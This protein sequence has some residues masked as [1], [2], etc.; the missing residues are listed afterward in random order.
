MALVVEN[1]QEAVRHA[2]AEATLRVLLAGMEWLPNQTGGLNRYYHDLV[3][4]LPEAGV[5][6]I[7]LVS[8]LRAGQTAPLELR[9]LTTRGTGLADVWRDSRR[10]V[11]R[12]L[13]EKIGLVNAH[14]A[15]YAW[16]WLRE[17][18]PSLPFVVHFHG[19][20]AD[21]IAMEAGKPL[22]GGRVLV[23]RWLERRVY[24]RADRVITLSQ[25]FA[26][27]AHRGYGVE[28]GKI[29]VV[30][31][32][33]DAAAFRSGPERREAR[34]RLGWPEEKRILLSVRRLTPRMGLEN[35]ITAFAA[36]QRAH[37]DALLFLAGKGPLAV[38]LQRQIEAAGLADRIRL[39]GFIPDS[40][41][42]LAYAAADITV[43]PTVALE[44]FGLVSLES[45]TAGTP[46]LGTPVGGTPEVL[47]DLDP[48]LL[49]D[50]ATP[51]ALTERLDA[52][53][54]GQFALPDRAA[55]R[56]YAA[57]FDWR[58]IAPRVRAVYDEARAIRGLG[59]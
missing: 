5:G 39:L 36:L 20:W 18:P 19:A 15:P 16:P 54:S 29:R 59:E 24:R 35:L 22:R 49:F 50:D 37:P 17:V 10:V 30:P 31:G 51:A 8:D 53:L 13:Q 25:A 6:G 28:R 48:R 11:R 45:L 40:D 1:Q 52:A 3:Q 7:A 14:F 32:G 57:R 47:R 58:Q 12:A 26:D 44:G 21:E 46:V 42:P 34:M 38:P 56:A 9:A 2:N 41:L 23:A 4:A 43:V 27:V 55:C 33:V